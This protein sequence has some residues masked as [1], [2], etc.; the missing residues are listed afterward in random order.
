[1]FRKF[2]AL[3]ASA[4]LLGLALDTASCGPTCKAG[5]ASCGSANGSSAAAGAGSDPTPTTCD[6]LTALRQCMDA[7]C[8]TESNPFCTCWTRGYEI[9]VNDCP[10]CMT[11]DSAGYCLNAKNAGADPASF[12]CS[13]ATGQ[14][15]PLCV[16]VQ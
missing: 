14:V 11:F 8:K 4:G 1:M 13:A 16:P 5:E 3:C 6:E 15:S 2:F 10:S 7:F 9:N 12:D